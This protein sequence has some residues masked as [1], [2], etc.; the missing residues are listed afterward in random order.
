MTL[1][2]LYRGTRRKRQVALELRAVLE[3][4]QQRMS[5]SNAFCTI[6]FRLCVTNAHNSVASCNASSRLST[7]AGPPRG[8]SSVSTVRAGDPVS[9]H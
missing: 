4:V 3:R 8:A 2:K 6:G 7:G 1:W 5:R 9:G